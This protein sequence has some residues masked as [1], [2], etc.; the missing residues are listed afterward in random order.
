MKIEKL[1]EYVKK[2]SILKKYKDL[3]TVFYNSMQTVYFHIRMK[4]TQLSWSLQGIYF[5]VY[6]TNFLNINLIFTMN[7]LLDI[8]QLIYL[9]FKIFSWSINLDCF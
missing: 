6:S 9:S 2:L 3:K 8:F 5:L 1:D 4:I 7:T